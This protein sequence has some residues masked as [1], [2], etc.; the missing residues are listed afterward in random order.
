M[1]LPAAAFRYDWNM[2]PIGQQ[3]WTEHLM[4]YETFPPLQAPEAHKLSGTLEQLKNANA[5][6]AFEP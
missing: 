4:S 5:S 2:S 1:T 6:H 3:L